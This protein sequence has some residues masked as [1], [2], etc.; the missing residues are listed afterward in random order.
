MVTKEDTRS[1]DHRSYQEGSSKLR[2]DVGLVPGLGFG[3]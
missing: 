2:R 1:L 3:V